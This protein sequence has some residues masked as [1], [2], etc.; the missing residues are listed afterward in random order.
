[1]SAH[2]PNSEEGYKAIA[3][4]DFSARSTKELSLT[5]GQVL[6]VKRTEQPDY[7]YGNIGESSGLVPSKFVRSVEEAAI[8]FDFNGDAKNL[9]LTAGETVLI[10][11][12]EHTHWWRGFKN[13]RE[14]LVPRLFVH[15]K[16]QPTWF[17]EAIFDFSSEPGREIPQLSL[18]K[19]DQLTIVRKEK[20]WWTG[21]IKGTSQYGVFPSNYVEEKEIPNG[22]S[23]RQESLVIAPLR[24]PLKPVVGDD[25]PETPREPTLVSPR[26]DESEESNSTKRSN[27]KKSNVAAEDLIDSIE[28]EVAKERKGKKGKKQKEGKTSKKE[29]RREKL[30]PR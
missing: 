29:K 11:S 15:L 22:L 24:L 5:K 28:E 14:G 4:F 19:G 1:M 20:G 18:K 2:S 23:S 3:L 8:L 13:G 16:N 17:A 21:C 25:V 30:S 27:G 10:Y 7:L 9:Q 26:A 12:K 6:F